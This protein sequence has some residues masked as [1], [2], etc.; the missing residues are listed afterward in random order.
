MKKLILIAF[1]A[2]M[3]SCI[4]TNLTPIAP[5][6]TNIDLNRYLGK[7]YQIA[8]L[9]QFFSFNAKCVTAEYSL[10]PDGSIKVVNKQI[11]PDG[12][13]A[14]I[15]GKATVEPN[16]GN[17]KLRVGFFGI[18]PAESNYWIVEIA[19]DYSYAVVSNESKTTWWILSRTP[20]MDE[21]KVQEII[22]RWAAFGINMSLLQRTVHDCE[23]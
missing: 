2:L 21:A 17:A 15:T 16:S 14:E 20:T 5:T 1:V 10:N 13:P 22:D 12:Q 9:P 19:D 8:A 6:S 11:G 18:Q 7:W 23:Q 3:T 4:P